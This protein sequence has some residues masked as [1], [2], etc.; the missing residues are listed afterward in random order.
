MGEPI[1]S[2]LND[3]LEAQLQNNFRRFDICNKEQNMVKFSTDV[4][5][6]Q[7]LDLTLEYAYK[8]DDYFRSPLGYQDGKSNEFI[9]DATL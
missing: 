8:K 7:S 3:T 6:I 9:L 5:P 1:S 2:A 4:S